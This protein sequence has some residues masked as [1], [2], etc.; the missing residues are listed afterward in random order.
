MRDS[1]QLINTTIFVLMSIQ[2]SIFQTNLSHAKKNPLH[3]HNFSIKKYRFTLVNRRICL[4]L[5][6]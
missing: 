5:F 2:V 3:F 1:P 4:L 6:K